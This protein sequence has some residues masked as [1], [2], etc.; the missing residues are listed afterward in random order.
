[1]L[2]RH[3]KNYC[4]LPCQNF[5]RKVSVVHG[6]LLSPTRPTH[7]LGVAVRESALFAG[8]NECEVTIAALREKGWQISDLC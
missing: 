7:L 1:M 2:Q 8:G 5:V 4:W 3:E 6:Q